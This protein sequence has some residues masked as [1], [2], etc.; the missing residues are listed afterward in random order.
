MTNS[1]PVA[2]SAAIGGLLSTGVALAA[3]LWPDRL[4]PV[5][6]AAIIAFGNSLILTAGAIYAMRGSTP[7]H[8]PTLP[9][10][11]EVK[12]QGTTDSVVIQPSPP[13]PVGV[14]GGVAQ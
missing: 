8:N 13:G 7:V 10:N 4:A 14:E 9:A 6:Q 11:T 5:V 3:V 12:V 2:V 1:Q